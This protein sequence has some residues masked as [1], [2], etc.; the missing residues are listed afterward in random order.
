MSYD[1]ESRSV[2]GAADDAREMT[3]TRGWA[4]L[5]RWV[6]EQAAIEAQAIERGVG[7]WDE[8]QRAVGRLDSF[9][10]VLERPDSLVAEAN[11]VIRGDN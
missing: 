9:R 8:Y 4:D 10:R 1:D 6:T 3:A 7:S 2:L 5:A 11:A